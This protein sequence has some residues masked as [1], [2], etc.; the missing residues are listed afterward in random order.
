VETVD[1]LRDLAARLRSPDQE[2]REDA[3]RALARRCPEARGVLME[4]LAARDAR[5]RRLAALALGEA[6]EAVAFGRLVELLQDRVGP[7]RRAAAEAL[8]RLGDE[9]AIVPLCRALKDP[10]P[11]VRGAAAVALGRIGGREVVSPICDTLRDRHPVVC[12]GA[13]RAL[14]QAAQRDPNL[15]LRLAIPL[16]RQRL[17]FWSLES[18]LTKEICRRALEEIEAA[19]AARHDLPLPAAGGQHPASLPLP[20]EETAE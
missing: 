10:A 14:T 17:S 20:G 5:V 1:E 8:G 12:R 19:T 2:V 4:A 7:V 16:L 11:E 9:R 18:R 6:R 3:A 15:A 13:G